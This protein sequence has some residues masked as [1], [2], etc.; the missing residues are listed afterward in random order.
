M[1]M[2]V[3]FPDMESVENRENLLKTAS[4]SLYLDN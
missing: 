1:K 3:L 2:A 4:F